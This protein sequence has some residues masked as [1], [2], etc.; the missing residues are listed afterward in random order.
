MKLLIGLLLLSTPVLAMD[1]YNF[2]E[3]YDR[4]KCEESE[5][6]FHEQMHERAA[7]LREIQR[8]DAQALS[9]DS[10]AEQTNQVL[11]QILRYQQRQQREGN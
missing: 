11:Q 10:Q 1:C 9:N 3:G 7:D 6:R 2:Q 5:A 8:E 4:Q